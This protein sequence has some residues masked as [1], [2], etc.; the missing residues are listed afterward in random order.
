MESLY[1][2]GQKIVFDSPLEVYIEKN[3]GRS[4]VEIRPTIKY[5]IVESIEEI[6]KPVTFLGSSESK[7]YMINLKLNDY[8][9]LILNENDIRIRKPTLL[10]KIFKSFPK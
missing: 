9:N 10:E 5:G 6:T 7:S 8:G 3:N 2:R 1:K 4:K